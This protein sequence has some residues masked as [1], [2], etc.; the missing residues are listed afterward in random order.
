MK[1]IAKLLALFLCL[2]LVLGAAAGCGTKQTASN[3]AG[4]ADQDVVKI[5]FLGALTGSV[6]CY[7]QPGLKGLELA[8]EELNAKG[9]ILGKKVVIIKE[10]NAGDKTQA[11]NII[12]NI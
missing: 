4:E 11:S 6:A 8:A 5:G 7:G 1:R 12:K 9:G 2:T 3:Q 10:D